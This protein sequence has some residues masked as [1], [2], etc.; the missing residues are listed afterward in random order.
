MML[1]LPNMDKPQIWAPGLNF[2][3]YPGFEPKVSQ[4]DMT[5][6]CVEIGSRMFLTFEYCTRLF[7]ES[8]I[9]RFIRY[10]KCMVLSVLDNPDQKIRGIEIVSREDKERILYNFNDTAA[11]YPKEKT[12]HQSF[13]EQ[14]ERTPERIAVVG[15]RQ[16]VAPPADK[17]AVGKERRTGEVLHLTYRELN[18]K[19]DQLAHLLI[20]KGALAGD[21][22]AIMAERSVEMMIGIFAILKAGGAY[23]PIDPGYPGERIQYML[24]DSNTSVLLTNK[25]GEKK[26]EIRISKHETNSN[27]Q[28]SNDQNKIS[29]PI[30]LN[31]ENLNFEFVSNFEFRA[32]NLYSSLAYVIYTSGSTGKPKGVMVEHRS[33]INRLNWMQRA[34]PLGQSDRILQKTPVV[35]DVSVWELFWWSFQGASLCLLGHGDEKSPEAIVEAIRQQGVTTMH[36]VPSMLTTFLD[37]LEEYEYRDTRDLRSLRQ[38]FASGEAL[39]SHQV[40]RFNRLLGIGNINKTRLIN[41]YGPTEATVDVSFFNCDLIEDQTPERIPIGKPIDNI[42]LIILSRY[43]QLLPIGIAGELCI[44]GDGVARGYV[45]R[46]EFTAEKFVDYRFYMSYRTYIFY[47]TGDLARWLANGNI[48]FLGRMDHQVKIRGFRIELGE[49]ENHLLKREDIKEAVVIAREDK[50]DTSLCA[51][52]VIADTGTGGS[53]AEF[54]RYLSRLLPDYMVP[55]YFVQLDS[56]PLT[57]NGK[58]DRKELPKPRLTRGDLYATPRTQTEKK[59]AEIWADILDLEAEIIGIDDRFFDLGGHSLKATVMVTRIHKEFNVR[60]TLA[61]IFHHG[62][63]RQL[64]QCIKV[65]AQEKYLAIEPVINKE[66]YPVSSAQ[67]RLYVLQQIKPDSTDYNMPL[68]ALIHGDLNID[69]LQE[70]LHQLSQRHEILRT[71]IRMIDNQPVQLI[72]P[73]CTLDIEYMGMQSK[74]R[75]ENI[76]LQD[77]ELDRLMQ[78]FIRPFDLAEPPLFRV[79]LI[80]VAHSNY[81]IMVDMHHVITDGASMQIF[82]KEF[83]TFYAGRKLPPVKFQYK[84]FSEWQNHLI[85]RGEIKR[86]EEYWLQQFKGNIPHLELPLDYP[87]SR[88]H[89]HNSECDG[90]RFDI[91]VELAAKVKALTVERETTPYMVLLAVYNIL[92]SRYSGQEDIVVGSAVAGR[93]HPD[94]ENIM[95]MFVNMLVMRNYPY[96]NLTFLEFLEQV[97]TTALNAYDNQDY[98]FDELVHKLGIEF[99][100]GRNPLFDTHFT[101]QN[102]AELAK[103]KE[104]IRFTDFIIN[105]ISSWQSKQPF[106]LGLNVTEAKNTYS[107]LL[108]YLTSLFKHSTIENMAKHYVEI[109]DQCMENKTIKIKDIVISLDL[110]TNKVELT[111]EDVTAFKF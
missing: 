106:D 15:S 67:K 62:T 111:Q 104:P 63:I 75:G 95:G 33:V 102:A 35:F 40:K 53:E 64:A 56:M 10:F 79:Q 105:S 99:Q 52:I 100:V 21:I 37:Y 41:L 72:Q 81:L 50:G 44:G 46:P 7:K 17:G 101:F 45:N 92:L 31:F 84:D 24:C 42:Q 25:G 4:F 27:D 86:Q 9:E 58:V 6:L 5:L 12:I 77:R 87:R 14:V 93:R 1:T 83:M 89:S 70:A 73:H 23:L 94:V 30:V 97:K 22:I 69:R 11:D 88:V 2:S 8:T 65:K 18:E 26:S 13:E 20:E 36:F 51:Y 55:G 107:M 48:E 108:G 39:G 76:E 109:L 43:L 16:G 85:A 68:Y 78:D 28:N 34:Y 61:E 57:P 71:S 80:K 103:E 91:P 29:T 74:E 32:S 90:I 19:S 38:V 60:L 98:Q 47:K 54:K 96:E 49:I 3:P 66:Y 110:V 82:M 59:L